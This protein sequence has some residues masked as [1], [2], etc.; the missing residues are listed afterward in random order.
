MKM[1]SHLTAF[2]RMKWF[3]ATHNFLP[4]C[5]ARFKGPIRFQKHGA[6]NKGIVLTNKSMWPIVINWVWNLSWLILDIFE[7]LPEWDWQN[8]IG[9]E[10]QL[11]ENFLDGSRRMI[12][13]GTLQFTLWL[14]LKRE[15]E[16]ADNLLFIDPNNGDY[17]QEWMGHH[18]WEWVG[19]ARSMKPSFSIITRKG[20][21]KPKLSPSTG[22]F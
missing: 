13:G 8:W 22:G 18:S 1:A 16:L 20:T 17:H 3:L 11:H 6:V 15:E 5:K 10:V 7:V 4:K 19:S 14:V 21:S 12:I 2:Q 9:P